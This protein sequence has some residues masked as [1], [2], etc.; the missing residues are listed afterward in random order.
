MILGGTN[1][2][3]LGV[4]TETI[5][6]ETRRTADAVGAPSV[7]LAAIAPADGFAEQVV[8]LNAGMEEF[9][10][11]QGWTFVDPWRT[12]GSPDGA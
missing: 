6:A 2:L 4:P 9:A 11:D 8:A 7:A 3:A 1:D 10:D 12:V 5:L